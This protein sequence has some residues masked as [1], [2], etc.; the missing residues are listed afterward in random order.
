M[1]REAQEQQWTVQ[2][3][4]LKYPGLLIV[5]SANGGSRNPI[6]A[7][8][9]KRTG[10]FP[11]IPD[12]QILTARKGYHSLFIEMKAPATD[13]SKK[14]VLTQQQK[15]CIEYLN[16]QNYHAAVAY[17]FEEARQVIDWYLNE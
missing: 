7:R 8:N 16:S 4:K 6:E 13:K 3:F 14:G 5:A 9:L 2:W 1:Q 15:L 10:V 12:L 17:G 11:G